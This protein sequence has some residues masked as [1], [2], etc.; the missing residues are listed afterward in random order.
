MLVPPR[1][2]IAPSALPKATKP[3][4]FLPLSSKKKLLSMTL[5]NMK[6]TLTRLELVKQ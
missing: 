1:S 6:D 4:P 5:P 2:L 3:M